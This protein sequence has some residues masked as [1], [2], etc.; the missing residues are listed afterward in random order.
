M[1]S[2]ANYAESEGVS[3]PRL[4]EYGD[5]LGNR[6]V[7]K[8]LGYVAETLGIANDWLLDAC[9]KRLSVGAG[10]LDPNLPATGPTRSRWRLRINA[11]V[12]R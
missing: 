11:R 7:F 6:T 3:W 4:V 10:L 2:L 5:R 8:R 12:E 9:L 1:E